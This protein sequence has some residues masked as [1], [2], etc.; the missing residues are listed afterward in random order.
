MPVNALVDRANTEDSERDVKCESNEFGD[1]VT[2]GPRGNND[3][4]LDREVTK[5]SICNNR[6]RRAWPRNVFTRRVMCECTIK[7]TSIRLVSGAAEDNC[8]DPIKGKFVLKAADS[9]GNNG[10]DTTGVS[11]VAVTGHT[12]FP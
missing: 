3:V 4:W 2:A 7:L 9:V 10:F 12:G 8:W 5:L 11:G 6:V 1:F